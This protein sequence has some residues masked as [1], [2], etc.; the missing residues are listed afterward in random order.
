MNLRR[1]ALAAALAFTSVLPATPVEAAPSAPAAAGPT[2]SSA[3]LGA[4]AAPAVS[5]A[6]AAT[7]VPGTA[8][9]GAVPGSTGMS[10]AQRSTG[11]SAAPRGWPFPP[12]N[13]SG[14]VPGLYAVN[15]HSFQCLSA[16]AAGGPASQRRCVVDDAYRWK[17]VP[18]SLDARFKVQNAGSGRC[19]VPAGGLGLALAACGNAMGDTWRLKDAPGTGIY[20]VNAATGRCLTV[21]PN[22]YAVQYRC[23]G[24][25]SRR[26]TFRAKP[27]G[28]G[29]VNVNGGKP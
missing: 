10:A 23:D 28:P 6:T 11:M 4:T 21:S 2:A 9:A 26:W 27:N 19:L 12:I 7:A 29:V 25:I 13:L 5:G 1:A 24:A 3:A 8:V 22:G 15:V 20:V 17:L 18:A 14:L 16:P